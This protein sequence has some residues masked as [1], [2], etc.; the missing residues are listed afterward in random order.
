MSEGGSPSEAERSKCPIIRSWLDIP[1]VAARA[2]LGKL[3]DVGKDGLTRECVSANADIL[4]PLIQEFGTRP[5]INQVMDVVGRF[6]FLCRP[7]G[8]KLPCSSAIKTEAWI[9]RR[10]VSLFGQVT[11]RPHV[12]RDPRLRQL[13]KIVGIDFESES[14]ILDNIVHPVDNEMNSSLAFR[15]TKTHIQ[16]K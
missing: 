7:R 11:R 12:P 5:S 1:D 16:N 8:R 10:L 4:E 13:F 2:A 3:A 14:G 15:D 9:L 6:L